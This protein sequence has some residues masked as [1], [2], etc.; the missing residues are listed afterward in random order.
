MSETFIPAR[1]VIFDHPL[2][3]TAYVRMAH[4]PDPLGWTLTDVAVPIKHQG[5]GF[6]RE[7]MQRALAWA[8][9]NDVTL[10]ITIAPTGILDYEALEAWYQRLGFVYDE[11]GIL[12]R[13]PRAST[14]ND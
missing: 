3:R 9:E 8:D 1:D 14:H 12:R 7:L 11:L 13:S 5:K 10:C 4:W 2:C 6:G